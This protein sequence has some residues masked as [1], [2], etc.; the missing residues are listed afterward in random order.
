M[1]HIVTLSVLI[2]ICSVLFRREIARYDLSPLVVFLLVLVLV[3]LSHNDG[4]TLEF[5]PSLMK[6]FWLPKMLTVVIAFLIFAVPGPKVVALLKEKVPTAVQ[7]L[8]TTVIGILVCVLLGV[9]TLAVV[10]RLPFP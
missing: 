1:V 3:M 7:A 6:S 2:L 5:G 9:I 10:S 8:T 4:K